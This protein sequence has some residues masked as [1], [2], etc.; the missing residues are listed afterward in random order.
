[1]TQEQV[2]GLKPGMSRRQVRFVLGSPTLRDVFHDDRWDYPYT[3]G[4]GSNPD[5]Y[6]YLSIYFEGDKLVR[7]T[8]DLHPQPESQQETKPKASVVTVPDYEGYESKGDEK[9]WWQKT[10]SWIMD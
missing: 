3:E 1:M 2:N 4:V 6:K 10:K 8:G 7:V 5:E 9:S